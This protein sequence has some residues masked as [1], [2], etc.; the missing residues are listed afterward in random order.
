MTAGTSARVGANA[1]PSAARS[2]AHGRDA[3]TSS[4]IP[5]RPAIAAL[6][7]RSPETYIDPELRRRPRPRTWTRRGRRCLQV[8]RPSTARNVGLLRQSRRHR[9]RPKHQNEPRHRQNNRRPASAASA[10]RR[11]RKQTTSLADGADGGVPAHDAAEAYHSREDVLLGARR[12]CRLT[13]WVGGGL[14]RSFF[15]LARSPRC[16]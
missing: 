6:W 10:E 3:E 16:R 15:F 11:R 9:R 1:V 14:S 7:Y 12:A 5:P 4:P 8:Q 2:P 13:D